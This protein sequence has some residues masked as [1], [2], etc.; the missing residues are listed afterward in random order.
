MFCDTVSRYF[1]WFAWLLSGPMV[2]GACSDDP[3]AGA[4]GSGGLTS[5]PG[6]LVNY[7]GDPAYPDDFWTTSTP[8]ESSVDASGLARAV[9]RIACT[10][11]EVHSFLLARHGRILFEQ[12]GWKSGRSAYDPDKTPHQTLPNE[13]HVLHSTTKS[14]ISTLVGIAIG[15]G[16]IP[17]VDAPVVPYFPEYQPLPEPSPEK[18]RITLEDL[19]TMRSGLNWNDAES[20]DADFPD[21]ALA[22][23]SRP[24]V[25]PPG[26]VWNYNDGQADVTAAL[27]RK[28]TGNT[29]L[30]YANQKLFGPVG[31][32]D[33]AWQ[34]SPNGTNFGGWGLEL[35]PREMLRFGEL[36]RNR[37]LWNGQQ[38]V[39]ADWTDVATAPKCDTGN[40]HYGYYFWIPNLPGFF[41]ALGLEGQ[42]IYISRE[43]GLVAVFTANLSV[44][45][46]GLS[47]EDLLRDF[48]IPAMK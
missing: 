29:P 27:L 38:I 4:T 9:G 31:L 12:Y 1:V 34:A 42:D 40:A 20:D 48:V 39:P 15:G 2:G 16:L 44:T 18:D 28:V 47:F 41:C 32:T 13:R 25:D 46:A 17:G 26:T 19:L 6:A 8:E 36:Y 21:P 3:C 7:L 35:T 43:L 23:L 5:Q 14:F 45:S 37:G 24:M 33:V 30:D 10:K 22:I 11:T